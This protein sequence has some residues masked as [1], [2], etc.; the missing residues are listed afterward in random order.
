MGCSHDVFFHRHCTFKSVDLDYPTNTVFLGE[1]CRELPTNNPQDIGTWWCLDQFRWG[2]C[3]LVRRRLT[4]WISLPDVISSFTGPLLWHFENNTTNDPSVELDLDEVKALARKIGFEL[5]VSAI[6]QSL[7]FTRRPYYMVSRTKRRSI[8]R[9]LVIRKGC[10]GTYTMR[11]S[12]LRPN[13]LEY[14]NSCV[15]STCPGG[16]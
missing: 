5:S 15:L 6:S 11:S 13:C 4:D 3:C 7:L 14:M 8:L 1:E 12:G 2:S 16:H 10:L 9:T